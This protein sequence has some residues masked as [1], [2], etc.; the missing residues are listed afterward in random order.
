MVISPGPTTALLLYQLYSSTVLRYPAL[1]PALH[2]TTP[3]L[4]HRPGVAQLLRELLHDAHHRCAQLDVPR[5]LLRLMLDQDW[6]RLGCAGDS[7][8]Q[9]NARLRERH[10]SK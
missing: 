4:C 1:V 10:V 5:P 8:A 2:V 6:R 9:C 3:V 7:H